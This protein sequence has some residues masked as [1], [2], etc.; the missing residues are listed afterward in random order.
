[1]RRK[2]ASATVALISWILAANYPAHAQTSDSHFI[3]AGELI[4]N[5]NTTRDFPTLI[6]INGIV[7]GLQIAN[8]E[9]AA[10]DKKPLYCPP[11]EIAFTQ[12]QVTSIMSQYLAGQRFRNTH[13]FDTNDQLAA[14][15]I[16][17]AFID[18]FPC[19]KQQ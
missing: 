4:H 17:N 3:S 11:L 16:L 13:P 15:V 6:F 7:A 2:T 5:M 14:I 1:M 10:S 9:L 8:V 18:T 19:A 12:D